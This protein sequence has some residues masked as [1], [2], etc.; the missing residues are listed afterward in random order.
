MQMLVVARVLH[1]ARLMA[2][3]AS[4]VTVFLMIMARA[5]FLALV[6]LVVI[7][8]AGSMAVEGSAA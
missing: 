4:L 1:W 6:A 5:T 7:V 8:V 3:F 2:S